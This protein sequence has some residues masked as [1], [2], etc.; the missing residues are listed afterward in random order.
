MK[1]I[2]WLNI[3]SLSIQR[4]TGLVIPEKKSLL[5]TDATYKKRFIY[6]GHVNTNKGI[7]LLLELFPGLPEDYS[8]SIYGPLSDEFK[9]KDFAV[10]QIRYNGVI[11][12]DKVTDVLAEHDVL[13][14]PTQHSS[15]GYPGVI[16]EAYSVGLPVIASHIGGIPE[17]VNDKTGIL[18]E[19]GNVE[20]LKQAVLS[21]D[22]AN[23]IN[24][25][26]S[27]KNQ[28]SEFDSSKVTQQFISA[29]K[30]Q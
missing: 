5:S 8:I 24:Y 13:I 15:E 22:D 12:P 28:F 29:I 25:Q 3:S 23:Y 1:L 11:A 26:E 18:F 14:L 30:F 27:A 17:I 10:S 16:I 20:Q 9:E 6:I 19:P 4:L 2:V 7:N 21:F